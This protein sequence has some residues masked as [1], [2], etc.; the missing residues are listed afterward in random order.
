MSRLIFPDMKSAKKYL[1]ENF[2]GHGTIKYIN[3]DEIVQQCRCSNKSDHQIVYVKDS[4][5]DMPKLNFSTRINVLNKRITGNP[6]NVKN[7]F[8][9]FRR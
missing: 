4:T 2:K 9:G 6:F 3:T 7:P 5:S 8:K 1:S